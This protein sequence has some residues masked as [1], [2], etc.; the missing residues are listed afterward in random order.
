MR[1]VLEQAKARGD[2]VLVTTAPLD[3]PGGMLPLARLC[4]GVIVLAHEQSTR[5]EQ[6]QGIVELLRTTD[7]PLLGTMLDRPEHSCRAGLDERAG[8]RR[9][10]PA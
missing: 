1:D 9:P 4:D 10:G 8:L 5:A 3:H 7:A 6:A 2:L